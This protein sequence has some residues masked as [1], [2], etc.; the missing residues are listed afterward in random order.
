MREIEISDVAYKRLQAL[1]KTPGLNVQGVASATLESRL[2][3]V[4]LERLT[5]EK[6][7]AI[8]GGTK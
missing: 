7:K 5:E 1:A 4:I 2:A 6:L 3:S 8:V